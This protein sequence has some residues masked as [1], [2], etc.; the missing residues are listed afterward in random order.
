MSYFEASALVAGQALFLQ[1]Y[2]KGEWRLPDTAV[3]ASMYT[4]QKANPFLASLRTRED[5]S[6]Y[7]YIPTRRAKGTDT[8]REHD[9]TGDRGDSKASTLSW[10]SIVET[11][12]ISIKQMDNNLMSF[13]ENYAAQLNS[14]IMNVLERQEAAQL[15]NLIADR[16]EVNKGTIQGAWNSTDNVMEIYNVQGEKFFQNVRTSMDNNLFRNNVMVVVDSLAYMNADFTM[17]QG[18]QNGTNLGFQ[19][20]GMN[21]AKTTSAIDADYIGAAL[22][23]DMNTVGIVPW[24]P[25][26]NRK[27][28]DPKAAL[29]YNGDYGSITVP[30]YDDKGNVAYTLDFAIHSYAGRSDSSAKGGYKQDVTIEVEVSLDAAYLSA[31]LSTFRATGTWA[32]KADSMVYQFGLL[33]A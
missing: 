25:V 28:L 21:I 32:G 22:A 17:N 27:P 2:K 29:T 13:E 24:I 3:L 9:H 6:V 12:S 11:F 1:N 14:C 10:N 7:A 4:G 23:F 30:V 19:H 8:S 16:T 18:P 20:A 33:P 31:P 5:R 15:A 26:Q